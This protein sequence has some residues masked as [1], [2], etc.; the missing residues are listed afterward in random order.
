MQKSL[1]LFLLFSIVLFAGSAYNKGRQAYQDEEYF[2][3]L[4]YFYVSARKH[5]TNAYIELALMYE[6]G[7]G[8]EANSM[9]A[10]YW[11]EKAAKRGN[12]YAKNRLSTL[13]ITPSD[14]ESS[15]IWSLNTLW[16]EKTIPNKE[17]SKEIATEEN[18]TSIWYWSSFLS[19]DNETQEPTKEVLT[20]ESNSSS[21]WGSWNLW[22]DDNSS[23]EE[24]NTE[25]NKSSLWE[26]MKFW[27]DDEDNSTTPP[28][29][30]PTN[31]EI[32]ISKE[33]W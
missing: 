20:Q 14:K 7:I 4:K 21:L 22:S 16:E 30:K 32:L 28:K 25:T 24:N 10:L 17:E 18:K 2:K 29:R 12:I 5:N 31:Q 27:K 33:E 19:E 11:Y 9:T 26:G 6:K 13:K 23:I 15:M 3:A 8:T 1:F